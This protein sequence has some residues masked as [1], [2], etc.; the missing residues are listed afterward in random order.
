MRLSKGASSDIMK[1]ENQNITNYS[2]NYLPSGN[3]NDNNINLSNRTN[4]ND[5]SGVNIIH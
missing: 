5:I 2:K 4:N 3:K 1:K